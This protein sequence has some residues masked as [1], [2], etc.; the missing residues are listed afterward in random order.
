MLALLDF[1]EWHVLVTSDAT[2]AGGFSSYL[3]AAPVVCRSSSCVSRSVG[4]GSARTRF[5]LSML[6]LNLLL[7]SFTSLRRLPCKQL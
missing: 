7:G 4:L 5:S 1:G 6:K 3:L 2:V